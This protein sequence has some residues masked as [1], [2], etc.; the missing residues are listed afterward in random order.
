MPEWISKSFISEKELEAIL[1]SGVA[2][3][4]FVVFKT[5]TV[6]GEVVEFRANGNGFAELVISKL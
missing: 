3:Q 2:P 6:G 5:K 1:S 4:F